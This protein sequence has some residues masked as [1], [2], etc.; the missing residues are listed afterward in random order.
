MDRSLSPGQPGIRSKKRMGMM[1]I[2]I[3]IVYGDIG[4]SPMYVMKSILEGNGGL[5]TVSEDFII[6]AFSLV[7]WTITLLTTIQF[8]VIAMKADNNGEGGIFALYSLVKKYWKPLI[9]VAM[10]GGAT[11]LADGVLTPAVTVTNAIDGLRSIPSFNTFIGD[12]P[13][14]VVVIVL[15]ILSALFSFQRA[16]TSKIG[17]AFGPFMLIW[18]LFLG[19]TGIV[20]LVSMPAVLKAINPIYAIKVLLSPG[21]KMGFMIL[22]SVFLSTTGAEA[23]YSDMGHVGKDSI[24][25]SWP[26]VK[27]CLLLN[28]GGQCAWILNSMNDPSLSGVESLNPFFQ[29]LTPGMRPLAVLISTA[30]SII[31]SQALITGSFTLVSEAINLDL[32][33]HMQIRYP[34]DQKG[35]L[36]ISLVNTIMWVG[37]CLVVL[38][39]RTASRIENAY[40]LAITISM[41]MTTLLLVFYLVKV[42]RR[43]AIAAFVGIV[44]GFIEFMFFIASLSKFMIGGYV[45]ILISLILLAIMYVWAQGTVIEHQH[46][47]FIRM[48]DYLANMA[49]L[50]MDDSIPFTAD[51]L[52]FFSRSK[53][54][55]MI[56]RDILYSIL[57]KDPKRARAYWFLN[58]KTTDQPFEKRYAVETYGTEYIFF[59]TITLGFKVPQRVNV[60]LRQIVQDLIDTG[61]LPEQERKFSIY[62]PSPIGNFKF[63]FIR[64]NLTAMD[65]PTMEYHLVNFKYRIRRQIGDHIK[66]YGLENSQLIIEYVPLFFA[67]VKPDRLE[68]DDTA[69]DPE[70]PV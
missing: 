17:K 26:F 44:F 32:L 36:Y 57:D 51:N 4:T 14:V 8:V 46:R 55:Q 30:A 68:R 48:K 37:C 49:A 6:G 47:T 41:L 66:W 7:I 56:E 22:G 34:S 28:Y 67:S 29:M 62:G 23:L 42:K 38:Y 18:F 19:V 61:E 15:I 40:G 35:Q 60:Y 5:S 43:F 63:C 16:G 2:A 52:V 25:I 33:P 11:M 21:N 10:I 12:G 31:A 69:D 27:I 50:R 70:G 9:Y 20:H 53:D 24:Y 1:L 39:F 59:V 65:T 64:N 54:P 13:W 58:I 45:A 3:G